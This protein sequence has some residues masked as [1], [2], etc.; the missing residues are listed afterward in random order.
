MYAILNRKCMALLKGIQFSSSGL[1]IIV[2]L[3]FMIA[4]TNVDHII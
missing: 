3:H 4:A 2:F 1:N